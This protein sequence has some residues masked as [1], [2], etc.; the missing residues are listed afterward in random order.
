MNH[1]PESGHRSV[2]LACLKWVKRRRRLTIGLGRFYPQE[3]TSSYHRGMSVSCPIPDVPAA[4]LRYAA[5]LR[6]LDARQQTLRKEE[7]DLQER[8]PG[9]NGQ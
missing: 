6:E 2:Q 5:T 1:T 8:E 7:G 4:A 3:R 9:R